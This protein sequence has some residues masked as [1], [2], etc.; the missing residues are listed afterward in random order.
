[1]PIQYPVRFSSPQGYRKITRKTYTRLKHAQASDVPLPNPTILE[2][3]FY[4]K[5]SSRCHNVSI[6]NDNTL[7]L[8]H[9]VISL[10]HFPQFITSQLE[11]QKITDNYRQ[12]VQLAT[13]LFVVS[14]YF[15]VDP[16]HTAS[17]PTLFSWHETDRRR[18]LYL[19]AYLN[20][21]MEARTYSAAEL[22][23]LRQSQTSETSN[24]FLAKLKADPEC[25]K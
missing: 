13:V 11:A 17:I 8:I 1:M 2:I 15:V 6:K 25:G 18:T 21:P 10:E 5:P 16:I 4:L 20:H 3:K 23:G 9:P 12:S 7:S 19:F 14:R 24:G 22:L